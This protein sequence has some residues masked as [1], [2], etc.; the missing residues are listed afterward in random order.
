MLR[1]VQPGDDGAHLVRTP[2]SHG[3]GNAALDSFVEELDVAVGNS[4]DELLLVSEVKV[5]CSREKNYYQAADSDK[6][7]CFQGIQS[8]S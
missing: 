7:F 5:G 2:G 4:V 1:V 8:H 3:I 6:N